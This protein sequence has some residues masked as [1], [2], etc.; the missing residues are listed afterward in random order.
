MQARIITMLS[1][2]AEVALFVAAAA[3]LATGVLLVR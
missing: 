3:A 2:A 1:Q